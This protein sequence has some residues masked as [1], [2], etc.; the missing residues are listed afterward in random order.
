[1]STS[2]ARRDGIQATVGVV[3][4]GDSEYAAFPRMH[5]AW[6]GCPPVKTVNLGGLGAHMTAAAIAKKVTP[7]IIQLYLSIKNKVVVC[8][9][10]E[11][12]SDC[13]V[14]LAKAVHAEIDKEL[15]TKNRA[16]IPY[17]VVLSDRAFEAWILAG[18]RSLHAAKRLKHAPAFAC[19]EGQLGKQDK[20]GVI[21][22]EDLLGRAYSKTRDGPELFLAMDRTQAR[23]FGPGLPGSQSFDKFL[24]ELGT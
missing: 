21:E 7:K 17:A 10:R 22:I 8:I 1:M 3:V 11:Q 9:D 19:F 23:T 4:E 6:A 20:K 14:T 5:R 13:V 2:R 18:A 15:I 16:D 24:R 12:R